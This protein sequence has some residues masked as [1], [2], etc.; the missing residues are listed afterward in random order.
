MTVLVTGAAGFIASHLSERLL[1]EGWSGCRVWT[2]STTS[3]IRPSRKRNLGAARDH[4]AFHP[5]PGR[6]P[7]SGAPGGACPK[8]STPSSTSRPGRASDPPSRDPVL[9]YDVNVT[10]TLNLLELARERGIRTLRLRL[11]LLGVRKQREG[12]LFGGRPGGQPHLSLC[13]HQEGRRTPSP[14]LHPSVWDQLPL[15]A[16]L[17][18][19]WAPAAPGS[20]HSQVR[21]AHG[22]RERR[23]PC[24]GMGPRKRDYT[25]IDDILQGLGRLRWHGSGTNEGVHEIV[26]L[27][28]SRTVEPEGDDPGPGG[29]DGDRAPNSD[30]CRSSREMWCAPLPTFP[31]PGRLLGYDP[32]MGVSGWDPGLPGWFETGRV[33]ARP[34]PPLHPWTDRFPDVVFDAWI[35]TRG[36]FLPVQPK[37][38]AWGKADMS[39]HHQ[40]FGEATHREGH[41]CLGAG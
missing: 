18:R 30:A 4:G 20:G 2:T 37:D 15:P 8:T 41:L 28:E 38:M 21:Q 23:S 26:N 10:G 9:Y 25:Y 24:S 6:H 33:D 13:G 34:D 16:V 40:P 29:G 7:G 19:L 36:E 31:R 17:H 1:D 14:F 22:C 11:L 12:S 27:G 39:E 5:R 32:Q 3:M 35:D